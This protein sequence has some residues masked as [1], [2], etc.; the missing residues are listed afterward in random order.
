MLRLA[1]RQRSV[2]RPPHDRCRL[3]P[4]GP[5]PPDGSFRDSINPLPTS[6]IASFILSSRT[7]RVYSPLWCDN[8][9][10][11]CREDSPR[12]T[13]QLHRFG[14]RH[15]VSYAEPPQRRV[16]HEPQDQGR[17]RSPLH[18]CPRDARRRAGPGALLQLFTVLR[19]TVAWPD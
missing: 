16:C 13:T 19:G 15:P 3:E 4:S 10:S 11:K 1:E 18:R 2:L 5:P 6:L 14:T 17:P 8:P 7:S 12:T 9:F